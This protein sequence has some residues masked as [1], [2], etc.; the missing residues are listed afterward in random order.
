MT[1]TSGTLTWETKALGDIAE[2]VNG[3]T[4]RKSDWSKEGRPIIRIQNL[5][6]STN[7]INRLN[8]PVEEKYIVKD[9]TLLLSWSATLIPHIY[10]GEDAVLN[11]H[12]FKVIPNI[13]KRFVY[14]LL[15]NELNQLKSKTHGSGMTHITKGTFLSHRVQVPNIKVQE[16]IAKKLDEM[17]SIITNTKKLT[18]FFS[19]K[20]LD[21]RFSVLKY[22]F[23]G[24]IFTDFDNAREKISDL[25]EIVGGG[26]PSTDNNLYW[27]EGTPWITSA[28]IDE[29]GNI[30]VRR[31]VTDAGIASS[32]AKIVP[33]GSILV[34]TRVGLGKVAINE[35]NLCTN[36]DI[37]SLINPKKEV[38]KEFMLQMLKYASQSFTFTGRGTTIKGITKK[39]LMEVTIP[40]VS[41]SEQ[42]KAVD[43]IN[44]QLS[45]IDNLAKSLGDLEYKTNILTQAILKYAFTGNLVKEV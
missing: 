3:M 14:H 20:L 35:F 43:F 36:Q 27:G 44:Q 22:V 7:T 33:K 42:G 29:V 26:T 31:K 23:D 19:R 10:R 37:Q 8:I 5:T 38:N 9:D 24:N 18:G 25:Y 17:L 32:A 11:Q 4:I 2:Y 21:Y 30:Q 34:V 40:K 41:L 15:S 28:D 13:N 16:D 1:K 12:I 45:V 39:T 6:G